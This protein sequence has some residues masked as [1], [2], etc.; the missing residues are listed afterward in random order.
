MRR[1]GPL[2]TSPLKKT[3]FKASPRGR[4][5]AVSERELN[6]LCRRLVVELRDK[7]T[8]QRCGATAATHQIQ[9][10]H[11]LR[12]HWKSAQWTE[13]NSLALCSGCHVWFDGNRK[14]W[15]WFAAKWP[16]RALTI[17][18]WEAQTKRKRVDLPLIKIYLEVEIAKLESKP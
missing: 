11:V 12:R 9:W 10:C 4:A 2:R 14:S 16:E 3:R 8:C 17:E 1:S 7:S 13:W 18:A 6:H 5:R 15:D